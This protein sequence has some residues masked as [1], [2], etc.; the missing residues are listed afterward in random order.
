MFGLSKWAYQHCSL[1]SLPKVV[2]ETSLLI[3]LIID[4]NCSWRM[5]HQPVPLSTTFSYSSL[6]L[7][8]VLLICPSPKPAKGSWTNLYTSTAK[9]YV[10]LNSAALDRFSIIRNWKYNW[11]M[12]S[13]NWRVFAFSF[14]Y[15]SFI[16]ICTSILYYCLL[17]SSV[18]FCFRCT[19]WLGLK[20]KVCK[21]KEIKS[22]HQTREWI[23]SLWRHQKISTSASIAR[24]IMDQ[25]LLMEPV[26]RFWKNIHLLCPQIC[27][28]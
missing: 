5:K 23:S 13:E 20:L 22:K 1:R 17:L 21:I 14:R 26:G 6:V 15:D 25:H 19:S 8:Y 2:H 18:I 9:L 28:L 11:W 3:R 4:H 12:S 24:T 10:I 16:A 27:T 7:W